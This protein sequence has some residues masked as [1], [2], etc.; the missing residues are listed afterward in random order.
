MVE[1]QK[2]FS[3]KSLYKNYEVK[4]YKSLADF[5]SETNKDIYDIIIADINV[6]SHFLEH[7]VN[8]EY[9]VCNEN[10][11]SWDGLNKILDIFINR[12]LSKKSR[13]LVVGGGVLQDSVSFC[14]SIFNRGISFDFMPTTLLSMVDSCIGGKTSINFSNFKNKL[15]NF[16]PPD[17]ILINPK[18]IST[19]SELEIYSGLGEVFKFELLQFNLEFYP[20]NIYNID[21]E[22]IIYKSLKYKAAI[23]EIDEFD[24]GMRLLLNF[25]H[26]FGHA[27][28]SLAEYKVPH[29]IAV[30]LGILYANEVSFNLGRMSRE[31]RNE[32]E[33]LSTLYL[34]KVNLELEWFQFDK[35]LDRLKKDKK[36][37]DG[38]RL[39]LIDEKSKIFTVEK[40]ENQ[41]LEYSFKNVTQRLFK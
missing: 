41:V 25:G 14:C 2:G 6:K 24:E 5:F 19:L 28:E 3:I 35:V 34:S 1:S 17:S 16:Y 32:I 20:S 9:I 39:V 12:N 30:V 15:G 37:I 13:V 8:V 22:D 33:R 36:N 18:F 10:T 38:I 40:V 27:F 29:G 11:K 7:V 26:S 21:W 23:L 4:F 31:L